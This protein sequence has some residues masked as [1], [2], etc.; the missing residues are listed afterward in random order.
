MESV[1][2]KSEKESEGEWE[3]MRQKSGKECHI[4]IISVVDTKGTMEG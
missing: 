4:E 2:R 1:K 3:K